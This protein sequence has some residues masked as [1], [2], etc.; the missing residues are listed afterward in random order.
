LSLTCTR[1]TSPGASDRVF[2]STEMRSA[3]LGRMRKLH[4]DC[5]SLR[6]CP[7]PHMR[8]DARAHI[9]GAGPRASCH[10][11]DCLDVR[12][13]WADIKE[14]DLVR[15]HGQRLAR[16]SDVLAP[17]CTF[18][19]PPAPADRWAQ[20]PPDGRVRAMWRDSKLSFF[21]SSWTQNAGAATVSWCKLSEPLVL[22]AA[23]LRG[24]AGTTRVMV[25][26]GRGA[27]A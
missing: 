11:L 6:I 27:S 25:R 10:H 8:H 1:L 21:F 3:L 17:L 5:S 14:L 4:V 20:L 2:G 19:R 15:V 16:H 26:N 9:P 12:L 7:P 18:C 13:V 24:V 22:R 23:G